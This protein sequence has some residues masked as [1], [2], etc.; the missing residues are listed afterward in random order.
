MSRRTFSRQG[1]GDVG[2]LQSIRVVG[3]EAHRIFFGQ[4]A[5][6]CELQFEVLAAITFGPLAT[7]EWVTCQFQLE[8]TTNTI[9]SD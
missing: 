1:L 2:Q 5:V 9:G 7:I 6:P 8:L 4:Q 3:Q